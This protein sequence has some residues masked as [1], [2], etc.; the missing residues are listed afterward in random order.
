MYYVFAFLWL[1]KSN[2]EFDD[3]KKKWWILD[4]YIDKWLHRLK[5]SRCIHSAEILH[6]IPNHTRWVVQRKQLKITVVGLGSNVQWLNLMTNS[7]IRAWHQSLNLMYHLKIQ[8]EIEAAVGGYEECASRRGDSQRRTMEATRCG[9][10]R[11]TMDVAAYHG[12]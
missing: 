8:V 7:Q 4:Q 2:L 3:N 11:M 10:W 9:D 6:Y 12:G 1:T 5:N